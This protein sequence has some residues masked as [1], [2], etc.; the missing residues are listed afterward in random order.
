MQER[1]RL[2]GVL[3]LFL[4]LF[5]ANVERLNLGLTSPTA[6]SSSSIR[7]KSFLIRVLIR[8]TSRFAD[9]KLARRS[10]RS[11]FISRVNSS[12]N[13]ANSSWF[14]SFSWSALS[15]RASTSSRRMVRWLSQRP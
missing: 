10:I 5:P 12:Q 4:K 11:R 2:V 3:E 1:W 7:S 13:S 9:E 6:I 8:S 15:T 14:R